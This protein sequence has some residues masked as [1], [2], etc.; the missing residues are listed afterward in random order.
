MAD[1]EVQADAMEAV[2]ASLAKVELIEQE[3]RDF[4][5][6]YM[7]DKIAHDTTMH[8]VQNIINL[9]FLKFKQEVEDRL[10]A[11]EKH[12]YKKLPAWSAEKDGAKP[13][14]L[15]DYE[16]WINLLWKEV[17]ELIKG[18]EGVYPGWT[19][20]AIVT[21]DGACVDDD[22]YVRFEFDP[23]IDLAG[24]RT[25]SLHRDG[26][27]KYAVAREL[28]KELCEREDRKPLWELTMVKHMEREANVEK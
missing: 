12:S 8:Q 5:L 28:V 24:T 19:V 4:M 22:K 20:K 9:D 3:S 7:Q 10:E 1:E 15:Q 25:V 17:Y 6:K 16:D 18:Q 26:E 21:C 11:L 13:A 23:C 14:A 27:E 2:E